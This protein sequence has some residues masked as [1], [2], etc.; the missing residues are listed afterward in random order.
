VSRIGFVLLTHQHPG[1]ILRLARRLAATF[2]SAPIACHH[3]FDRCPL[4]VG[5]FPAGVQFVRP[6]VPTR[7]GDFS[8]VEATLAGIRALY[9]AGPSPDWFTLVSGADYPLQ[10]AGKVLSD[11]QRS[12]GDAYLQ[13][14]WIRSKRPVL[15][16]PPGRRGYA[17]GE[18]RLAR[19]CFERYFRQRCRI[20]LPS[21]GGRRRVLRLSTSI[22]WLVRRFAPYSDQFRCYVGSQWLSANR[23]AAEHLLEWHARNPWLADHLRGRFAP[24]ETY[25]HTVLGNA[26]RLRVVNADFRYIDWSAGG[27]N[28]KL[29]GL[30]DLPAML[31]SDAHFARKFAPDDPVLDRLDAVLDSPAVRTART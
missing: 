15:R 12:G 4:D 25:I 14:A 10:P 24:D 8:L 27:P 23:R 6:H 18:G 28:P 9:D 11:L 7:W 5:A 1:Q 16:A 3:D 30:E 13:H 22:P 29:L 20:S 17:P 2:D 31:A 21:F 26:P 19:Q